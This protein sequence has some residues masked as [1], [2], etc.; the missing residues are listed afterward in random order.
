[1]I[2]DTIC[3]YRDNRDEILVAFLYN[4]IDPSKREAFET[5]LAA[6]AAC[7]HA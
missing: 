4:D 1:M 2:M 7:R 3:T 5:H 6:C